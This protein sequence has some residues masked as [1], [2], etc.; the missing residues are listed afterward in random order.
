[1]GDDESN[2]N[3]NPK[4]VT[5]DPKLDFIA[6]TVAGIAAIAVGH[7]FDTGAFAFVISN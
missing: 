1:M 7:P 4:L 6:G 5:L 3:G 2:R